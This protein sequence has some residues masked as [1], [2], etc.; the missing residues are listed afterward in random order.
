MSKVRGLRTFDGSEEMNRLQS[1]LDSALS[2]VLGSLIV[3]GI[4]L[5]GLDLSTTAT[6]INHKLGRLPQGWIVVDKNADARVWST[7][8]TK[9]TL[10]LTASAT[11][12]VSLW[13]Y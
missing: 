1:N 9:S 4:Q 13:V 11:C 3:D 8:K 7:A 12:T 6:K 5:S 2:P 10:T